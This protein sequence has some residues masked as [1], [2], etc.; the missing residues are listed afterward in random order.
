VPITGVERGGVETFKITD[1]PEAGELF[2][3]PNEVAN[4]HFDDTW[5]TPDEPYIMLASVGP[6]D[7]GFALLNHGEGYYIVTGIEN[8]N[9]GDVA[10][11]T[12]IMENLIHYAVALKVSAPVERGGKLASSWGMIKSVH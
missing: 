6:Q 10:T 4:A 7:I 3:K 2:T 12:P 1:A 5:T 9:A 8:E 11:N